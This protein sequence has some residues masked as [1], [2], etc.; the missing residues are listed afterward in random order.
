MAKKKKI[1]SLAEGTETERHKGTKALGRHK[2]TKA[3]AVAKA[4]AG[5]HRHKG[6]NFLAEGAEI[7]RHKGK[8][9]SH[10]EH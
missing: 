6:K 2:G 10:R 3:P 1:I 7:G 5:R 4:M 8:N 9:V